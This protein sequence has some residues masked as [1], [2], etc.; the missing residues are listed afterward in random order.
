MDLEGFIEGFGVKMPK[1]RIYQ[2]GKRLFL[3]TG[4]EVPLRDRYKDGEGLRLASVAENDFR[5]T[6]ELCQM[7]TKGFLDVDEKEAVTWMCGMDLKK[8]IEADYVIIKYKEYILG[9]GK[10]RGGRIINSTPKNR[11][12]PLK[13]L[14]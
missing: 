4:R 7:A 8:E 11:R 12:L 10:P 5:P 6:I 9:A 1:G 2:Q 13:W 14:P 3:F